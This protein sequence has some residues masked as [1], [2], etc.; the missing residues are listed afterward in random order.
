MATVVQLPS[1]SWRAQIRRKG[2]ATL[3]KTFKA[4]EEADV[5][6]KEKE[7][8]LL[9]AH[10]KAVPRVAQAITL[11]DVIEKYFTSIAFGKKAPTTQSRE[12]ACSL[13]IL[14]VLGHYAMTVLNYDMVQEYIEMR[15]QEKVRH[16]NGKVLDKK[17][18]PDTVRL[19][20]A[21][22]S[23][24]V[25]WARGKKY[26]QH[27]FMLDSFDLPTCV[28][29][30]GRITLRQQL[31]L[32]E[33]AV[34]LKNTPGTN[35]V[36]FPWLQFIFETGTRPG[37]AAKIEIS[38]VDLEKRRILIPRRSQKKRN[39]R[40]V[41]L[42]EDMA[43]VL[44]ERIAA[45]ESAG[46][47]FVFFSRANARRAKDLAGNPVRRRR[48]HLETAEREC[49]PYQYYHAW[50]TVCR[51]AGVPT[52]I[53]P[54]IVRHEFISRLFEETDLS[55]SQIATLVGDVNVLSLGP[56]KHVAAERLR[57]KQD[58]HLEQLQ[59]ALRELEAKREQR[60]A[61]IF[62]DIAARR[63]AAQQ[64][65]DETAARNGEPAPLRGIARIHA[66]VT[67]EEAIRKAYSGEEGEE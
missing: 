30:E 5:W 51:H 40:L 24:V 48:T 29:R 56:Y 62:A 61:E 12:R 23:S 20:K 67:A 47:R 16:K 45:G 25:K 54:H 46:S 4:R 27:N 2:L 59:S 28:P 18:S 11:A 14:E 66:L 42:T 32:F 37:E 36:L 1:G 8:E 7:A 22:L 43:K 53:N 50:R 58:R 57:G 64:E 60:R 38:W 31:R 3:N 34:R 44:E 52:D 6:A 17:V 10:H 41:L 13:R 21:F 55:D 33:E 39:P 26:I 19:E 65:E 9:A 15:S 35:P 63:A 49:I